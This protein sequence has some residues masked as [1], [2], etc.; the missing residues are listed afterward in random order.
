MVFGREAPENGAESAVLENF[1]DFS[2]NIVARKCNKKQK[3]WVVGF[4]IFLCFFEKLF[5]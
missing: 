5:L 4:K 1:S 2:E 3:V